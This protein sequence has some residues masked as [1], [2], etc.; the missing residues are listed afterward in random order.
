MALVYNKN[1][2]LIDVESGRIM[3]NNNR[4]KS[5]EGF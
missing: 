5:E 1:P 3:P 2:E 4:A